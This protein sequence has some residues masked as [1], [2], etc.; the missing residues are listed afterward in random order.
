MK[1]NKV[2]SELQLKIRNYIFYR[3][4]YDKFKNP[5]Q[6]VEKLSRKMQLDLF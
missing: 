4:Y 1:L 3:E 2:P 5:S 6:I